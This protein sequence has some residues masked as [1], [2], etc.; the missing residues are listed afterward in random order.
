M[1]AMEWSHRLCLRLPA[2]VSLSFFFSFL[3]LSHGAP[4]YNSF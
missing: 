4:F 1:E 2:A 3:L